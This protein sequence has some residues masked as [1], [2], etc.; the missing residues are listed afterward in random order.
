MIM[1]GAFSKAAIKVVVSLITSPTF[2]SACAY[3]SDIVYNIRSALG[4]PHKG[5]CGVIPVLAIILSR[6]WRT[7]AGNRS[8]KA[9]PSMPSDCARA[10]H[11][12]QA[13]FVDL[14]TAGE[15]QAH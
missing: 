9:T 7:L 6:Y 14:I 15:L 5:K 12:T 10:N 8:P 3:Y 2:I 11:R 1:P 13:R 4:R